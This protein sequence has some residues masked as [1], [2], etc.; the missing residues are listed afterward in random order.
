[1][2]SFSLSSN[3]ARLSGLLARPFESAGPRP[4]TTHTEPAEL[5][6]NNANYK[7]LVGAGSTLS[8]P[9]PLAQT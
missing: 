5:F 7:S 2:F 6:I 1:M 8:P 4:E 3:D 9:P